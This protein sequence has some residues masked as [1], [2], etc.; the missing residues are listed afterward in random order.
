V[1]RR[2]PRVYTIASGLDPLRLLARKVLDGFPLTDRTSLPLHAWT[3]LLPSRRAARRFAEVLRNELGTTS[4][5]LPRILPLGDLDAESIDMWAETDDWS[6]QTAG[7]EKLSAVGLLFEIYGFVTRWANANPHLSLAN[8]VAASAVQ[9]FN[10][11]RSL[12]KLVDQAG[13]E[14]VPLAGIA[15]V[16]QVQDNDLAGHRETIIGLLNQLNQH[17][18]ALQLSEKRVTAATYRNLSIRNVA[19][20]I[21]KS[22]MGLPIVA[23]GS[24]GTNP[25]TRDLLKAIAHAPFGAL[26]LPGLDTG[27][28]DADWLSLTPTH[29]Q[30][31]LSQLLGALGIGTRDVEPLSSEDGP[32]TTLAREMMR[33]SDLTHLWHTS[34]PERSQTIAQNARGLHLLHAADRHEEAL[35]IALIMRET[36]NH[37]TRTAALITPDRELAQRVKAELQ[38]WSIAIDDSAGEPLSRFGMASLVMQVIAVVETDFSAETLVGVLHHPLMRCGLTQNEYRTAAQALEIAALRQQGLANGLDGLSFALRRANHERV[39]QKHL[40]PVIDRMPDAVWVAMQQ[41]ATHIQSTLRSLSEITPRSMAQH[42]ELLLNVLTALAGEVPATGTAE[43]QSVMR[44]LAA[45]SARLAPLSFRQAAPVIAAALR[46]K[47]LNAAANTAGRLAIYGLPESRMMSVDVAI[48]GGLNETIWPEQPD[49]G[50]WLNRTM[51]DAFKLQQPERVIGLTAHDLCENL[52]HRRVFLTWSKRAGKE[53]LVPSRWILR[54]QIILHAAGVTSDLAKGD[55]ILCLA[56]QIDAAHEFRNQ[57][58]PTPKP[59]VSARPRKFSITEIET[60]HRDPYAIYAKKILHLKPLENL[61]NDPD[62]RMR[63]VIFHEALENWTRLALAGPSASLEALFSEGRKAFAQLEGD[64]DVNAFWWPRF[65]RMAE[66]VHS[67]DIELRDGV[68]QIHVEERGEYNF[69][70]LGE[71]FTLSGRADRI[72]VFTDDTVRIIDYKTGAPPSDKT[73]ESGLSPQ[74]TLEAAII[75]EGA[76]KNI[77]PRLAREAVYLYLKGGRPPGEIHVVGTSRDNKFN[78]MEIGP[79]HLA[80]LKEKLAA[81]QNPNTEYLPRFALKKEDTPSDYDHLSRY[82]EW[83]LKDP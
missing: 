66:W 47:K 19:R 7:P 40:H 41:V 51:R 67:L 48:L 62:A 29:P 75:A 31:G 52:G 57:P 23:A 25:A 3:I 13:T 74:M 20:A 12:I 22:D 80:R 71:R 17:L 44:D 42:V 79:D 16:Y 82:R 43:F 37:P 72:D 70:I 63:G 78:L 58:K 39:A 28:N 8:D 50:P 10:L 18:E 59:P 73:V 65:Q 14:E 9:G 2:A 21:T 56:R 32:R 76:F 36:L 38:R 55:A 11:A 33:S 81:Y 24:T 49:P 34:I 5:L 77:G 30:W 83:S 68:R 61:A 35:A 60:L 54:L 1:S 53:P 46:A 45:E 4:L 27:M 15:G 26:I 69:D 6:L 64:P